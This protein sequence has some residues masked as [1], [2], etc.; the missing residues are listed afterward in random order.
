[1]HIM[2][3]DSL[4][5]WLNLSDQSSEE[6]SLIISMKDV[7]WPYKL[8]WVWIFSL[9]NSRSLYMEATNSLR[10]WFLYSGVQLNIL[11]LV[12]NR[13][14]HLRWMQYRPRPASVLLPGVVSCSTLGHY[15]FWCKSM[16]SSLNIYPTMLYSSEG[17]LYD[18]LKSLIEDL[19][20]WGI[21]L[22]SNLQF[23]CVQLLLYGKTLEV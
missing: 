11:A 10:K 13:L 18:S 6:V 5:L 22:T 14:I 20:W 3:S 8:N 19:M 16:L 4:S 9:S 7:F 2:G 23:D 21:L 15:L 12:P 17:I 1:M